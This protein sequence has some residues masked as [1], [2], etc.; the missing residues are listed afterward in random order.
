MRSDPSRPSDR[1]PRKVWPFFAADLFGWVLDGI[2][3]WVTLRGNGV[4]VRVTG[5]SRLADDFEPEMPR[6]LHDAFERRSP[7]AALAAHD[8]GL[9]LLPTGVSDMHPGNCPSSRV[10]KRPGAHCDAHAEGALRAEDEFPKTCRRSLERR[11]ILP[12]PV[13]QYSKTGN[14]FP[15]ICFQFRNN[16]PTSVHGF[17]T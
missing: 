10:A 17:S 5:A 15:N 13:F 14:R 11:M 6:A 9:G 16:I 12:R 2:G 3:R 4:S 8:R 7:E 1:S